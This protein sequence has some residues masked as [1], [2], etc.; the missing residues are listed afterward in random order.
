MFRAAMSGWI[1]RAQ[2]R[3]EEVIGRSRRSI[4]KLNDQF[5]S[6]SGRVHDEER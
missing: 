6:P 1:K 2:Q 5:V 3:L 4:Q